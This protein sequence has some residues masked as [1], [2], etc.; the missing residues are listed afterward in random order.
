RII[1]NNEITE[2]T[3][4]VIIVI[5]PNTSFSTELNKE[6]LKNSYESISGRKFIKRDDLRNIESKYKVDHLFIHFSLGFPL[7]F[8]KTGINVIPCDTNT[9]QLI[10]TIQDSTMED[11]HFN[12]SECLQIKQLISI[13][14]LK[15]HNNIWKFGTIDQRIFAAM[16]FIEKNF[17]GKITN[18][19]LADK[20]NMAVNSF[21]R[22]FKASTGVSIQ[23]YIIKTKV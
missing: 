14:L 11:T 2:L 8:V 20:A 10:E 23:Q 1:F 13:C 15:L 21:A 9:L 19:E 12:F 6:T 22:L 3:K 18:E 16:K 7:D 17:N 5:P 4:D